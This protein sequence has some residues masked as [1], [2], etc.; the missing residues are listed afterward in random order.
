MDSKS[1]WSVKFG[2]LLDMNWFS[3]AVETLTFTRDL[4]VTPQFFVNLSLSMKADLRAKRACVER[5]DTQ[6]ESR[7]NA[8]VAYRVSS[9]LV[10]LGHESSSLRSDEA[11]P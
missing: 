2:P 10:T 4:G 9:D 8:R 11:S 7:I 6:S 1:R 5:S 3:R